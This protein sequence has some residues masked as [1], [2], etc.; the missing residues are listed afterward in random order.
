MNASPRQSPLK[1]PGAAYREIFKMQ[2]F[3]T[4]PFCAAAPAPLAGREPTPANLM[5]VFR[6]FANPGSEYNPNLRKERRF[7]PN[8][9]RVEGK[10]L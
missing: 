8:D 5:L 6:A 10:N 2:G 7:F 4:P 3:N 9:E 1:G